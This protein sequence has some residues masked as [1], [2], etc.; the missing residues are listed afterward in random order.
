MLAIMHGLSLRVPL[1]PPAMQIASVG[2]L[3]GEND[4]LPCYNAGMEIRKI[5]GVVKDYAWGNSDFIPSLIGGATGGPQA[6]L[7][8]GTHPSGDATVVGD[9]A[10]SELIRDDRSYLGE[11]DWRRFSGSLP[12]LMK[13]LAI[14]K[15]LSLQCHPNKAQA[16][17]GWKREE[18]SR[19]KGE[20]VSYQDVNE[21][22]E[23]ILALSPI[24]AMCGFREL[25]VIKADLAAMVPSAYGRTLRTLSTDIENLFMSLF[26]LPK[27]EKESILAELKASL[28]AS[29]EPSWNSLF[30]TRAGISR[31][32]LEEY[33]DDIGCIFPYLL[34]VVHLQ[35]GEAMPIRPGTLHAYVFGNGIELMN[36]SDNVLRGGL[37]K[38][39]M[40]LPEL[41]SIMGFEPLAVEKSTAMKDGF[42]RTRFSSPSPDYALLSVSSGTYEIKHDPLAILLVT[43]GVVRFS[44]KGEGLVLEKGEAAVIPAGM[45][46]TMTVRGS[47]YISEVADAQ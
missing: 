6:E 35:I 34:N 2:P 29:D 19:R 31:E 8:L 22:C 14:A 47:A 37:T 9:G 10:L 45:E 4:A 36:A 46:Y 21:K 20:P 23:M 5:K 39:R 42:G 11:K 33:P 40:D 44:S 3:C 7:W 43:E 27:E 1:L 25:E 38:K 16:E 30:L 15:P 28:E 13:V 17:A 18:E 24:T 12:L 41:R 26:G 32:C